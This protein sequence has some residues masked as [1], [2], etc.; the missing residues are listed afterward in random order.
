[1]NENTAKEI[2][3]NEKTP[4]QILEMKLSISEKNKIESFNSRILI[5]KKEFLTP[6][7]RFCNNNQGQRKRGMYTTWNTTQPLKV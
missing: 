1:M 2:E 5:W 6:R 3:L 7:T 4:I